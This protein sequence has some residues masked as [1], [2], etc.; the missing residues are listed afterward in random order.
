MIKSP[1]EVSLSLTAVTMLALLHA[2]PA[3]AVSKVWV[4]DTGVDGASCGAVSSPCATFQRAHDNVAAGGEIGVLTP[5]DYGQVTINKSANFTNDNTGEAAVLGHGISIAAGAG[6][7]VSLRGLVIDGQGGATAGV[8]V[9]SA[10]AVHIQNSVIR[11]F[12]GQN[13]G[14]GIAISNEGHTQ[15]FVS[16]TTILNNGTVGETGGILVK[17]FGSADVVLDRV[18]LEN[19]VIGLK[20]DGTQGSGSG[21][22]ATVR[23]S[24][25][26]GNAGNG[27]WSL[28]PVGGVP[29]VILVERTA[30]LNNAGAGVL[31][32]GGGVVLLSNATVAANGTGAS[33]AN[34]GRLFTYGNNVI[35]NN[36]GEDLS[37]AAIIRTTR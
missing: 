17:P 7:I 33:V 28:R 24:V 6:D 29:A 31:A 32:D 21:I 1:A 30:A 25:V 9:V 10:S 11:N 8:F 36:V 37:P 16:D 20:V 34:G 2:A 3:R 23:N 19:N 13:T 35:D 4:A 12:E 15:V 14:F 26:S 18:H 27:I 5:G 22:R